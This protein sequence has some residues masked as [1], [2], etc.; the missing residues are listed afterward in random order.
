[1]AD[2]GCQ[3]RT[4][5]SRHVQSC[6]LKL[7]VMWLVV[8]ILL[9]IVLPVWIEGT[10]MWMTQLSTSSKESWGWSRNLPSAWANSWQIGSESGAPVAS[11]WWVHMTVGELMSGG[12]A[13]AIST[14]TTAWLPATQQPCELNGS[15]DTCPTYSESSKGVLFK[16]CL[17]KVETTL[18]TYFTGIS[19]FVMI[20]LW[21]HVQTFRISVGGSHHGR[22][23]GTALP[24]VAEVQH[25]VLRAEDYGPFGFMEK[26]PRICR[27]SLWVVLSRLC[28]VSAFDDLMVPGMTRFGICGLV[29]ARLIRKRIWTASTW[30]CE[31]LPRCL[32]KS[33]QY[34]SDLFSFLPVERLESQVNILPS[35]TSPRTECWWPNSCCSTDRHCSLI[36]ISH[37]TRPRKRTLWV[38]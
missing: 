8:W 6:I 11:G 28:E 9:S 30:K 16:F 32:S 21:F 36:L 24:P 5:Q 13:R 22:T 2:C 10:P 4:C 17:S 20:C 35:W 33:L 19:W 27:E 23:L 26:C 14:L 15:L 25:V 34:S 31:I 18:N 38:L 3:F 29:E 7:C 1:M 12:T 37:V